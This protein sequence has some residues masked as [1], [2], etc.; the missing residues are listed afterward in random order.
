MAADI[1]EFVLNIHLVNV[2][3]FTNRT[4]SVLKISVFYVNYIFF[5]I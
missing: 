3:V 4:F 5:V 1:T 2:I